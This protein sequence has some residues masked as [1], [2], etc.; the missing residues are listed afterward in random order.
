[1]LVRGQV[2][3]LQHRKKLQAAVPSD[4]SAQLGPSAWRPA[5]LSWVMKSW[6]CPADPVVGVETSA[7]HLISHSAQDCNTDLS[8]PD[9]RRPPRSA[10][11][12]GARHS[13]KDSHL[14]RQISGLIKKQLSREGNTKPGW[15]CV[16]HMFFRPGLILWLVSDLQSQNYLVCACLR[17]NV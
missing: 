17:R 11:E 4:S 8:P 15:L 10:M 13:H 2:Y 3:H 5:V 6:A 7:Q 9:S 1:M 16:H 12:G 14:Q